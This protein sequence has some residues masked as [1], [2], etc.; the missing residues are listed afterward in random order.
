MVY[1]FHLILNSSSIYSSENLELLLTTKISYSL[2]F[3]YV[4]ISRST[5]TQKENLPH[6]NKF[7]CFSFTP[8]SDA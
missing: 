2:F 3:R 5:I 6:F 8:T 4:K 7:L 1:F